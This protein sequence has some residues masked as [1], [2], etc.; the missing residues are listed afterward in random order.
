MQISMHYISACESAF[1]LKIWR[2]SSWPPAMLHTKLLFKFQNATIS[3]SEDIE[4][5]VFS[6]YVISR[7]K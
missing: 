7:L 5:T 1:D 3:I 2:S 4:E 6:V